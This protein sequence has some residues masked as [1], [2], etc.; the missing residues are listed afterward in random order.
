[1][2]R[3]KKEKLDLKKALSGLEDVI[4]DLEGREEKSELLL[5]TLKD[6]QAGW[7]KL[8]LKDYLEG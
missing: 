1:M 2:K 3:T 5:S 8:A 4:E 7:E 6:L